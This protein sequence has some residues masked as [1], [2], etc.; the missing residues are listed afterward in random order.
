MTDNHSPST[1][2]SVK[3]SGLNGSG[4]RIFIGVAWPYANGSL[5]LGH[6][7]ALLG[8][9]IAQKYHKEFAENLIHG[10]KF[11]YDLYTTTTTPLHEK[12]VQDI[13]LKLYEKGDIYKKTEELPYCPKCQRFLP[14]RYIEGECP[15]CQYSGARGDQCDEC[16]S[17]LDPRELINPKCKICGTKPEWRESEHFFLKLSA[18]EGQLVEWVKKAEGWRGNAKNFTLKY[19]EQGLRDRAITRDTEYGVPIPLPGYES[20]RIYVWFEAV[21]GYW[22]ASQEWASE[23]G[24]VNL[25]KKFWQEDD[26]LA[27]YVHGKDNIPFHTI[28]WPAM[29]LAHGNLHLPDRIISSEYLTL[30]K[31]QFSTSRHFAV[32]LPDFLAKFPADTLRYYLIANGPET[33]DADFTWLEFQSRVNAELIGN[34][35]NFVHRILSFIAKHFPDGVDFPAGLNDEQNK[36]IGLAKEIYFKAGVAIGD[37]HFREALKDIFNLIDAGNKFVEQV[38]SWVK[39][40]EDKEA[41]GRDLAVVANVIANLSVLLKPFLPETAEKISALLGLEK[42]LPWRYFETGKII[43]ANPLPIFKKIEDG[44]VE[45][46]QYDLFKKQK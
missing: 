19:L 18:F 10:L 28:I 29:L 31:K 13:F 11:S 6:V 42:D 45:E 46:M 33:A 39:I 25:W 3:S 15:K 40:K 9:E 32:W 23:Q 30:E 14:D 24:D 41:T 20:K 37:G 21:S 22:S 1:G 12:V 5:H 26:I 38:S 44:A 35:G 16:G 34:F 27:Y 7:A 17:L 2:P 43:I 8:A 4:Q 36:F